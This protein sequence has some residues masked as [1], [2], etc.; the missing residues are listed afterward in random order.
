MPR[1]VAPNATGAW[2]RE[3]SRRSPDELIA[4]LEG[5]DD[6]AEHPTFQTIRSLLI[7]A[8]D[9]LVADMVNGPAREAIDMNKQAGA[10]LGLEALESLM[11]EIRVGGERAHAQLVAEAERTR[12][13]LEAV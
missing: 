13:N 6:L 1:G 3:L 10:I 12:P 2:R 5:V 4:L 11:R 9:E 7:E 8:H